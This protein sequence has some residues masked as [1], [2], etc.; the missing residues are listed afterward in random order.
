V[1]GPTQ[2]VEARIWLFV[3]AADR[4]D[5]VP[6]LSR[7]GLLDPDRQRRRRAWNL[8]RCRPKRRT[9]R[10]FSPCGGHLLISD[11]SFEPC[12][13]T[14]PISVERRRTFGVVVECSRPFGYTLGYM[15][16][17]NKVNNLPI[18][19]IYRTVV[20]RSTEDFN[21]KAAGSNPARPIARS[22]LNGTFY[23]C[24]QPETAA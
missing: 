15:F 18:C 19:R 8:C 7:H 14:D 16:D 3:L 1:G 20:E 10:D 17:D 24:Q 21:P 12:Q 4:S 2:A 11:A 13:Y 23:A 22:L 5:C 6:Q 9:A